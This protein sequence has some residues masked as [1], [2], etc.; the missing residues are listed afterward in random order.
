MNTVIV[1][2]TLCADT[3]TTTNGHV[4]PLKGSGDLPVKKMAN[5]LCIIGAVKPKSSERGGRA[6]GFAIFT[7][8]RT[9]TTSTRSEKKK[10]FFTSDTQKVSF[11]GSTGV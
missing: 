1:H 4:S 3:T 11:L 6:V 8:Q 5:D 10:V 7:M 2:T 9:K